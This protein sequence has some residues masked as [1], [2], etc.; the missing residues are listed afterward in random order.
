LRGEDT[1]PTG[2]AFSFAQEYRADPAAER[3]RDLL[4]VRATVRRDDRA[5][6]VGPVELVVGDVVLLEAGHQV[7]ADS[8]Q[9]GGQLSVD[10]SMLTRESTPVPSRPEP[11]GPVLAGNLRG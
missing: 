2:G 3:L 5:T 9:T 6:V 7:C 10:N 11:A 8:T 4:P 1:D